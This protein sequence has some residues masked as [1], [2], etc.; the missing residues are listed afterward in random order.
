MIGAWKCNTPPF[1]KLW[2]TD[3]PTDWPNHSSNKKMD[4]GVH[5]EVTPAFPCLHLKFM[6]VLGRQDHICCFYFCF[7]ILFLGKVKAFIPPSGEEEAVHI[8]YGIV[9]W[10]KSIVICFSTPRLFNARFCY[11]MLSIFIMFLCWFFC[12]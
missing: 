10:R 7:R 9:H 6:R 3:Q 8:Y 4:K 5:R 2:Q 12:I 11:V 1:R